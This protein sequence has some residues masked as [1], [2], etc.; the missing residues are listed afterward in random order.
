MAR[1]APP[2]QLHFLGTASALP[3]AERANTH[4]AITRG[5]RGASSNGLLIDCGGNVYGA[6]RRSGIADDSIGDLFITHAHIDH[7]GSLPSLLESFRL[8]GRS[9]PLGIWGLP[10]VLAVAQKLIA[11][12]AFELTLNQ[13]PFDVSFHPVEDDATLRLGGCDAR[14]RRM[15][16]AVPSAGIR[17][18]LPKGPVA[19]TSD[20][21]PNLALLDLGR[22]ARLLI[23]ECTFLREHEAAARLTKHMTAF[24]AGAQAAA[25]GVEMLA[26][27]HVGEGDGWPVEEALAEARSAFAGTILMP[28]D[29]ETLAV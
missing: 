17:L 3:S 27:V 1:S 15:D 6:L 21:Q 25:C 19:Y 20:T 14:I 18:E 2:A 11:V 10:E 8:G 4:L 24:E 22:Q 13:W 28:H 7:I 29:L 26:L 9:A 5:I 12:F 16:H 23:T